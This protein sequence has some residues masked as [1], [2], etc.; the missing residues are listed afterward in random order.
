M[1]VTKGI[2]EEFSSAC[3]TKQRGRGFGRT[4]RFVENVISATW[5]ARLR[6]AQLRIR[7]TLHTPHNDEFG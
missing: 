4:D 7:S 5:P 1:V 6:I 2:L 3:V